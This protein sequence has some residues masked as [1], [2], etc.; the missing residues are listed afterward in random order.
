MRINTYR[1]LWDTP[2]LQASERAMNRATTRHKLLAHNLANVNTPNF[3]RLDLPEG[4]WTPAPSLQ[5]ALQAGVLPMR[6]S[7]PRHISLPRTAQPQSTAPTPQPTPMRTDGSTID[8]EYE[9]AQ[10]AENELRYAMLA[11]IANGQIRT[12]QTA[13][14][15]GRGQ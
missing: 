12:L 9:L 1:T 10:L 15:E 5:R 14:R 11:R 2:T 4:E 3:M 6:V 13:I 7:D 8:P